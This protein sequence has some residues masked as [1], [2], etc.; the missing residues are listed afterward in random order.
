[1]P[2]SFLNS[3]GCFKVTK[4]IAHRV[5]P[6]KNRRS[7]SRRR[8]RLH[9]W[10]EVGVNRQ[11]LLTLAWPSMALTSGIGVPFIRWIEAKLWRRLW[12]VSRLSF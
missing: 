1:M 6:A 4:L 7:K 5:S 12:I 11:R 8:V 3:T 2:G 10:N 9:L